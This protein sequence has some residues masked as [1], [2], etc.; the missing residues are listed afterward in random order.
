M[1]FQDF[2][3]AVIDIVKSLGVPLEYQMR[4]LKTSVAWREVKCRSYKLFPADE[5][6]ISE[7][8]VDILG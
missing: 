2:K 1:G 7:I 3:S 5:H 8:L 4:N 6:A